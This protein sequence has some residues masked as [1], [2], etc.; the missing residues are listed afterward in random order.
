MAK[1]NNF[2]LVVMVNYTNIYS[3]A[4]FFLIIKETVYCDWIGKILWF[5]LNLIIF[6]FGGEA[7]KVCQN[8]YLD[9]SDHDFQW[10]QIWYNYYNSINRLLL[11]KVFTIFPWNMWGRNYILFSI[12]EQV[13]FLGFIF[14]S[15]AWNKILFSLWKWNGEWWL[16]SLDCIEEPTL[17]YS[18]AEMRWNNGVGFLVFDY[19]ENIH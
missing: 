11:S 14:K 9:N 18:V 16:D 6:F 17:I 13:V 15:A 4:F 12:K 19:I 10:M 5:M 1:V 7:L 3:C 2:F 8:M